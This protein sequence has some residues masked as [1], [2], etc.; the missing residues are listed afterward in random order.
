MSSAPPPAGP[1][2]GYQPAYPRPPQ[3]YRPSAWWFVLGI[4]LVVM[5][6]GIAV[7]IFIW[8]LAAFL[9]FDATID[10][11]GQPRNVTVGTDRDRMLWMDSGSQRCRVVDLDTGQPIPLRPVDG[12]FSRSDGNGDFE[13]LLRFDPRSGHLQIT[14]VQTDGSAPGTVLIGPVPRIGSLVAGVLLVIFVP[15][16]LGLAGLIVI[17]V[18]GVLWSSRQPRPQAAA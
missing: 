13:G 4:G 10:A 15:A 17:I 11:D 12:D 14:C 16:V 7:G 18:T 5:G 2:Y 8:L 6:I 1:P 3:K 9:H